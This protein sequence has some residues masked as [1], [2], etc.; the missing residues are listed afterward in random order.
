[1]SGSGRSRSFVGC[2]S[3]SGLLRKRP[4]SEQQWTAEKCQK[5]SL[6]PFAERNIYEI[7][8][9][10]SF[11]LRAGELHNLGPLLGFIGDELSKVGG[12][13]GEHVATEPQLSGGRSPD[14][15]GEYR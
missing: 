2:V 1:M 12:R 5:R 4:C 8:G 10:A 13:E 6:P 14:A 15:I 11:G 7:F 9:V 3:M